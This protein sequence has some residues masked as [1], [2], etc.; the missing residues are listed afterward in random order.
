MHQPD[1]P[2]AVYLAKLR[3]E[4]A[5]R[6]LRCELITTGCVPRLRL[7][8]PWRWAPGWIAD[9][10]FEDHGVAAESPDRQWCFWWPWIQPIAPVD[11][12]MSAADHI[13]RN[14]LETL[15]VGNEAE[16]NSIPERER[17]G[18]E[19]REGE[20]YNSRQSQGR[21]A[22]PSEGS[23]RPGREPWFPGPLVPGAVV[24][25]RPSAREGGRT[26]Q[27]EEV[28]ADLRGSRDRLPFRPPVPV[29]GTGQGRGRPV[30]EMRPPCPLVTPQSVA[31]IPRRMMPV[32]RRCLTAEL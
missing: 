30:R 1:E 12:V 28:I 5:A 10:A 31:G 13:L 11:D 29:R 20:A 22:Q 24:L 16:A 14:T 18:R 7:Y 2:Q 26:G 25:R 3:V 21:A 19:A 32:I 27:S 8:I 15:A 4:L 23:G 6:G 9:S 17:A